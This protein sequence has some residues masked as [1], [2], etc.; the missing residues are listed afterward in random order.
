MIP[1]QP[2]DPL[3]QQKYYFAVFDKRGHVIGTVYVLDT[4]MKPRREMGGTDNEASGYRPRHK[5]RRLGNDGE[6]QVN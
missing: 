3:F 6:R 5:L 4:E 2:I 1:D